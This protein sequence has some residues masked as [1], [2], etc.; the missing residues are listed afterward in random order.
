MNEY[1]KNEYEKDMAVIAGQA[2]TLAYKLLED[3]TVSSKDRDALE[4]KLDQLVLRYREALKQD[5]LAETKLHQLPVPQRIKPA[6]KKFSKDL[7]EL[8]GPFLE[9]LEDQKG[10]EDK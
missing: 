10:R 5:P 4:K 1:T 7:V 9:S 6:M 3:V 2:L 8:L